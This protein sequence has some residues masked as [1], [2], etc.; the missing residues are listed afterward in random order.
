MPETRPHSPNHLVVG[1][2]LRPVIRRKKWRSRGRSGP[3]LEM[4]IEEGWSEVRIAESQR[5]LKRGMVGWC[6]GDDE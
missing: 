1:S 3:V 2:V 4:G 5:G 6:H